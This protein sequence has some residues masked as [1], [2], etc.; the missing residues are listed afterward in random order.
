MRGSIR[1]TPTRLGI[2]PF[3]SIHYGGELYE[4][5]SVLRRGMH[6]SQYR[7]WKR[8]AMS[9]RHKPGAISLTSSPLSVPSMPTF[10]TPHDYPAPPPTSSPTSPNPFQLTSMRPRSPGSSIR[11]CSPTARHHRRHNPR[12]CK[13]RQRWWRRQARQLTTTRTYR[14]ISWN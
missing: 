1:T 12:P 7:G 14:A 10:S 2:E 8:G 9:I 6:V 3:W 13:S 5:V 11:T 4:V